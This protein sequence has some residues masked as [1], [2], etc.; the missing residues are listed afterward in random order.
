MYTVMLVD[1]Y[2]VFRRQIKRMPLWNDHPGFQITAEAGDGDEALRKLREAPVDL[3]ITD[4]KMP[5]VDGIELMKRA[6]KENLCRCVVLLSEYTDFEYARQGILLGA[7]DYVVKPIN[8]E[9]LAQMIARCTANLAAQPGS[10]M[11]AG[12]ENAL[13]CFMLE[14][15]EGLENKA[16]ALAQ[17]YYETCGKNCIRT[18]VMLLRSAQSIYRMIEEAEPWIAL[19]AEDPARF[20]RAIV[21]YEDFPLL[22]TVYEKYLRELYLLLRKFRVGISELVQK[23]AHFVL[24]NVGEKIS[25]M[26]AAEVLFTNKT[27]LSHLFKTE[28]GQSFSDFTA[29][30]KCARAKKLLR[31]TT[32]RIFEIAS[33]LSYE[34]AEYFSRSF[35]AITGYSPADYRKAH[36]QPIP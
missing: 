10:D 33:Q 22:S 28:T 36:S 23:C 19:F 7:F 20:E 8:E 26:R 30:A 25:L 31:E 34:D 6:Y 9:K 4:I 21:K 16:Q 3:L 1:D 32:L 12:E 11:A 27:Y 35:K 15:G 29:R 17:S 14:G 2:A 13:V 5:K 24:E 18:G